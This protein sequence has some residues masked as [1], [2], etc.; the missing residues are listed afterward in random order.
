VLFAT[1][2]VLLFGIV[3]GEP[4]AEFQET[5][6]FKVVEAAI[7][8]GLYGGG[9]LLILG[10]AMRPRSGSWWN[11]NRPQ[12][13]S[14]RVPKGADKDAIS[15]RTQELMAS[16]DLSWKRAWSRAVAEANS[17]SD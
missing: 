16:E 17:D 12:S 2:F 4:T 5:T 8:I 15:E 7:N 14:V 13:E 3:G 9:F 10:A 1:A 11:R 6:T